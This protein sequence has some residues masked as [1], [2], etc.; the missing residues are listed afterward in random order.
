MTWPVRLEKGRIDLFVRGRID[1][2]DARRQESTADELLLRLGRQPGVILADE[3]GMGK[4]FVALAVALAAA[5]ADKRQRPVVIMMPAGLKEKWE[6][7]YRLF[8]E[9]CVTFSSDRDVRHSHAT[10]GLELF[11]LLAQPVGTRPRIIFLTHGA[12]SRNL[13]D[14]WVK[15]AILKRAMRGRHIGLRRDGLPRFAS[16]IVRGVKSKYGRNDKDR[17]QLFRRLLKRPTRD[18]NSIIAEFGVPLTHS[19]VPTALADVLDGDKI[20]GSRD[21]DDAGPLTKLGEQLYALPVRATDSI[22]VRL[23][24]IRHSLNEAFRPIWKASLKIAGFD[25][26]LIVLDEAHHLKNPKT[27]LR[28]LFVTEDADADARELGGALS[29]GFERM[30]FL[31]ATPF[32]LG[33][34]E[35]LNV[36]DT[37]EGVN[38]ATLTATSRERFAGQRKELRHALDIAQQLALDFDCSWKQMRHDDIVRPDGEAANL[39]EWWCSVCAAPEAF[40]ERVQ[41]N[42]RAY[43][44]AKTAILTAEK[45]LCPWVIRHIRDRA[46]PNSPVLRRTRLV[47]K[48][49]L[50]G[51]PDDVAG[52]PMTDSGLLPFLL[53]ARA[54]SIV[55]YVARTQSDRSAYRATFAEGLASSFEAFL[56]TGRSTEKKVDEV[57]GQKASDD[58]RIRAYVKRL[59]DELPGEGRFAEHPKIAPVVRRVVSLWEEGEKVVV[60]CHYRITGRVLVRHISTAVRRSLAATAERKLKDTGRDADRLVQTWDGGFDRGERL[61]RTLAAHVGGL[62]STAGFVDSERASMVDVVRRFVRTELFLVRYV[63]LAAKNRAAALEEALVR[64]DGSGSS[65]NDKLRDFVTFMSERCT[66]DERD[67]YLRALGTIQPGGADYRAHHKGEVYKGSRA[68][69]NVRLASGAVDSKVRRR[70]L[71]GFNTPFLPEILIASSVMA[72]GVDLH[73]NCRH[74]IHHDLAWNPSTIEQRT[75]RIDRIGAKAERVGKS[76]EIAL[77]YVGGTQDEKMFRVV[78][79]RERWFQIVM[80]EKYATDELST[81]RHA[82]RV[83]LPELVSRELTMQLATAACLPR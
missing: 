20:D 27:E 66:R 16:D 65:L 60:F 36:L 68:L 57:S 82:E 15:F 75:G 80:G 10:N 71:L 64:P 55:A 40:P 7:D 26:P 13:E 77:P 72:E 23:D 5:W 6:G 43:S 73:L 34:V 48:G 24:R 74:M 79:D 62:I 9:R 52:L 28:S 30:L 54:Q 50:S 11:R 67:E 29:A 8:L 83:A 38:W 44:R 63:D 78:M 31:T 61:E 21:I 51:S 18:W 58:P 76:I 22:G 47:G 42:Y 25:S 14:P 2:K 32:Q 46:L 35:L 69:P 81:E 19:A 39:D 1:E 53:A 41:E 33:H 3:V 56:E 12:L 49:L 37:F 4:T 59:R 45:L 17:E 70:L